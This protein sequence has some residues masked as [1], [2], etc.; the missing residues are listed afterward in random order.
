MTL[1]KGTGELEPSA[2]GLCA[3]RPLLGSQQGC[4]F[5]HRLSTS[6]VFSGHKRQLEGGGDR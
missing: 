5:P 3:H 6:E 1:P 2:S 4:Y